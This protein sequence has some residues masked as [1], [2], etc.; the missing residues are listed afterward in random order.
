M[1]F[2]S[3][4]LESSFDL[5]LSYLI[6][7]WLLLLLLFDLHFIYLL[8]EEP[9]RICWLLGTLRLLYLL[10]LM[11]MHWWFCSMLMDIYEEV[12]LHKEYPF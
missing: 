8:L 6:A 3:G 5:V 10:V 11:G 9:L 1:V 7:I 2:I 12:I 4:R